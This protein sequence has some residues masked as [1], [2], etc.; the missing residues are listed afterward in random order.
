[1]VIPYG[2]TAPI[3]ALR[4]NFALGSSVL[5]ETQKREIR[6]ISRIINTQGFSRLVVNGFTDSSG[7][8]ALN[9]KLSE[10]RANSVAAYMRTLLPKIAIKASA[11][12]P[13]KPVASNDS[14]S[15]QAQNR[16]TEIATW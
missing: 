14:K 2:A 6:S 9:K 1:V 11:F 12:G 7:S 4:V 8:P 13:N 3:P 5:S 10:A 16:R 15:G